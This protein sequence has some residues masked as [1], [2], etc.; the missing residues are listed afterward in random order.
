[1]KRDTS[2][3]LGCGGCNCRCVNG[4][5]AAVGG[6]AILAAVCATTQLHSCCNILVKQQLGSTAM[7]TRASSTSYNSYKCTF[8][9]RCTAGS[10]PF[11]PHHS[12]F[13]TACSK[14]RGN[15]PGAFCPSNL[16]IMPQRNQQR[17]A[18]LEAFP[19]QRCCS[20]QQ[21]YSCTLRRGYGAAA[22]ASMAAAAALLQTP[23]QRRLHPAGCI[24]SS[25]FAFTCVALLGRLQ[26]R[27]SLLQ[28]QGKAWHMACGW[29]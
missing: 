28:Q 24:H 8:P 9:L 15:L 1:V 2:A 20:L 5:A 3:T 22:A 25:S 29:P 23:A 17:P 26:C 12:Q 27:F 14:Q 18:G 19:Q 16:L 4:S 11:I 13:H 7:L 21:S 10:P 6:A